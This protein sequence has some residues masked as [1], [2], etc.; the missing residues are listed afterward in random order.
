MNQQERNNTCVVSFM[1]ALIRSLI[2][3]EWKTVTNETKSTWSKRL[4]SCKKVQRAH[5]VTHVKKFV[6]VV[7]VVVVANN[8][9]MD[10]QSTRLT[11]WQTDRQTWKEWYKQLPSESTG[12]TTAKV[13]VPSL[14]RRRK[15]IYT[16]KN[17]TS[18]TSTYKLEKNKTKQVAPTTG[19][20]CGLQDELMIFNYAFF[21]RVKSN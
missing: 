16:R 8:T 1:R 12:F 19:K 4:K 9:F 20:Y 15:P 2:G 5:K 18:Q 13:V 17:T 14:S 3:R 11:D 6:V 10:N 21:S 7:V